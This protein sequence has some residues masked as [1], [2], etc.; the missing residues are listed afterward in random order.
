MTDADKVMNPQYFGRDP[1]EIQIRIN[2]AIQI[3][4]PDHFLL[5]FLRWQRFTLSDDSV[6]DCRQC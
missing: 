6:D 5:K 2:L 1:A 4:I 3:R